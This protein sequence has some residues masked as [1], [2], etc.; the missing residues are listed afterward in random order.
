MELRRLSRD[1]VYRGKV[2][3]L[4]VDRVEYPSGNKGV[5]EIAHHSGGAV[6]VPMFDDG[7]VL[8]V[9]QLRY[10]FGRHLYELPAGK[11]GPGE[12]PQSA[13]ARE[14]EEETGYVAATLKPLTSI[15]T[16]PGFC[17]EVLHV[18]LATGLKQSPGGPRREEGE[19]SMTIQEMPLRE[20][21][22]MVEQGEINDSKTIVGLLWIE[23]RMR[24]IP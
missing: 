1:V 3:D 22:V 7:R 9:K 11:L 19:S 12:D 18:F 13:A 20:A 10:P 14:L 17:D 2:F 4:I 24:E 16:T 21:L 15:Y 23:R 5:R 8:L 6:I